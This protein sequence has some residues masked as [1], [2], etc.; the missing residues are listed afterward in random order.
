MRHWTQPWT[1][2]IADQERRR[3][4]DVIGEMARP[5]RAGVADRVRTVTTTGREPGA[6]IRRRELRMSDTDLWVAPERQRR[7]GRR[8]GGL[9]G[10]D[11]S[12]A[13]GQGRQHLIGRQPVRR[14]PAQ[15]QKIRRQGSPSA[16]L[17]SS[18]GLVSEGKWLPGTPPSIPGE[19]LAKG[20][21]PR[22]LLSSDSRIAGGPFLLVTFFRLSSRLPMSLADSSRTAAAAARLSTA[23]RLCN[24]A[25]ELAH[26]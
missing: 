10:G 19:G 16:G 6:I 4:R 25:C 20:D 23:L 18:T 15:G 1:S 2:L 11:W 9:E 26:F 3:L 5:L 14:Q 7:Q 24:I 8:D 22:R 17:E 21:P 13:M 12:A